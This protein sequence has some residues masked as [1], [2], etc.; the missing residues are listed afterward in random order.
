MRERESGVDERGEHFER[1]RLDQGGVSGSCRPHER[2]VRVR[3]LHT[4][5]GFESVRTIAAQTEQ[6]SLD[7]RESCSVQHS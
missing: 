4:K 1:E 6:S 7:G 5:E 3:D 2:G